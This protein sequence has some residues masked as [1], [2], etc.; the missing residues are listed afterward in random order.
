M[1]PSVS[2]YRNLRCSPNLVPKRSLGTRNSF[3][4]TEPHPSGLDSLTVASAT[5]IKSLTPTAWT[6]FRR[7][8]GRFCFPHHK[9][10]THMRK[11]GVLLAV[12]AL[13]S[14]GTSLAHAEKN[15]GDT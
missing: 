6:D 14:L 5:W 7:I 12:V 8:P 4:F 15:K 9:E 2:R 13:V 10:R 11:L 3:D 1:F